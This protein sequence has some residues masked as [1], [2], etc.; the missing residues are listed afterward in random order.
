[1]HYAAHT[2]HNDRG[3]TMVSGAHRCLVAL[4]IV[5]PT[6]TAGAQTETAGGCTPASPKEVEQRIVNH[7][8]GKLYPP[9]F[10]ES[11]PYEWFIRAVA[12]RH[13]TPRGA[14]S[15]MVV[16]LSG[17]I[18]GDPSVGAGIVTGTGDGRL[19][20][21]TADHVIRR[22]T[23][24]A[25]KVSVTFPT[26]PRNLVEGTVLRRTT[27]GS[28]SVLWPSRSRPRQCKV[29]PRGSTSCRATNASVA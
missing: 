18:G 27:P 14:A 8:A 7:R 13:F 24:T 23:S 12:E 4:L 29:R 22:G 19:V 5:L 2:L 6:C 21:A 17:T 9:G 20:I 16:V 25:D 10:A 28:T 15:D 11:K 3:M 1:M 26:W